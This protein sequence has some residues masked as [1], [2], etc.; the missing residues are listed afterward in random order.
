VEPINEIAPQYLSLGQAALNASVAN[1][2]FGAPG[3]T[4]VIGSATVTRA[5]TLLPFPQYSTI[6]ENLTIAHARYNSLVGKVQKRLSGGLTM[7]TTI[8]WAKSMDNAFSS[9]N[10]NSL[11]GLGGA[12]TG[13]IQNIYNLAA[14]WGL[15]ATDTP[16]RITGSWSYDLPF[17]KGKRFL[18]GNPILNYIVGGWSTNGTA[19]INTGFPLFVTQTNLNAGIGGV[20]QRP[21]ATGVNACY[22]GSPESRLGSYLNPA[23]FSAA[24]AYTYGNLSRDI[25]CRAPGQANWDMSVFKTVRI[26]ER[27]SAEFRAEALNAF[28]TPL[29]APPITNVSLATF[30]RVT[31]QANIPRNLQLGLRFAW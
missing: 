16:V 7:L 13:G 30:G 5:Q 21:N 25:N 18:N 11:N 9:G 23:A 3:A 8:T 19:V 4:G 10:S 14:E 28:N 20:N 15:A 6:S 22:S 27:Y 1:P 12:G 24:G 31:Y 26:R 2:F 17:G 29:F